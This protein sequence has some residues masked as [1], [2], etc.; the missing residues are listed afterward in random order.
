MTA[1]F[2]SSL[3]AL[4]ANRTL[5]VPVLA[6]ACVQLWKFLWPWILQRKLDFSLL[7]SPGGMPSSHSALVCALAA[8]AGMNSGFGSPAFAISTVFA[9]IVMYDAAGVRQAAG[10]QAAKINQIVDELL[11]G[12]PLN[13]ERLREILGHTPF[14]VTMGAVFGI[15]FGWLLN[16]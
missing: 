15:L 5:W 10:K 3:L 1:R 8:S 14:Q 6:W 13:E 16:L 7:W 12:H 4:L 2:D 9:I 11:K